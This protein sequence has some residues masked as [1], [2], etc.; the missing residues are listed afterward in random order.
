MQKELVDSFDANRINLLK[1]K[2][3]EKS[4]TL[5]KNSETKLNALIM[6][7]KANIV[8]YDEKKANI[9]LV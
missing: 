8:E 1:D 7:S 3:D 5:E 9:S 2:L 4:N 6:R